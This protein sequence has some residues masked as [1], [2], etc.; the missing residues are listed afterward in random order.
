MEGRNFTGI[1]FLYSGNSF[2]T[3]SSVSKVLEIRP[4]TPAVQT[5]R[6]SVV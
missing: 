2:V 6:K 4:D 5:D 1:L 3:D